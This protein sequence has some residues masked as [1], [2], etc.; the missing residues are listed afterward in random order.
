MARKKLGF[1]LSG[2]GARGVA[3]AGFLQAMEENG[4]VPDVI[5]GCSMGAVVGGC[6]SGGV[7]TE[8]M[9]NF[10]LRLTKKDLLDLNFNVLRSR[11]VFAGKKMNS[12]LTRYLG[13][14]EIENLKIKYGC[15]ATDLLS[16]KLVDLINGDL[17]SAIRAS[18][19][20]P[21]VFA[22]VER[23]GSLLVDG[24]VL[25]RNPV[26]LAKKL[27]AEVI[28]GVDV[29]G[30]LKRAENCKKLLDVGMRTFSV[31]DNV[32]CAKLGT[33]TADLM[34]YP[35]IN[36]V[37]IFNFENLNVAY[38]SGYKAGLDNAEAIKKLIK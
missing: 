29:L 13:E 6:Y 36:D 5:S 4:I 11:S 3:H 21:A 16:G 9:K 25:L 22:P 10:L 2:G 24:G 33:K 8:T 35:E 26:K 18:S 37:E 28:I 12:I 19:A 14:Q 27:G 32:Y 38:E 15:I 20:I 1:S 23:N 17:V 30:G 31:I 34:I 7:S